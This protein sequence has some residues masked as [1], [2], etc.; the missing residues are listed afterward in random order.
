[1]TYEVRLIPS[2]S[3]EF[4]AAYQWLA[5]RTPQHAPIWYNTMADALV[6]LGEYPARCPKV[7]PHGEM[8]YLLFGDK[9]HAY[10]ICFKIRGQIVYVYS[11]RHAA[12]QS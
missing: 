6:S 10:R 11:I 3:A 4:D 8:R 5:E 2:A 1:M 9:H 12:R 7:D